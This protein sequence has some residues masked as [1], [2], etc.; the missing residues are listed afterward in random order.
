MSRVG[1][2]LVVNGQIA[3]ICGAARLGKMDVERPEARDLLHQLL[4]LIAHMAF[5]PAVIGQVLIVS[6]RFKVAAYA[7]AIEEL[8]RDATG[9]IDWMPVFHKQGELRLA[10]DDC[11]AALY[12]RCQGIWGDIPAAPEAVPAP[13]ALLE[14]S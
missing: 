13:V 12:Q 10:A 14:A 11:L 2:K 5:E 8:R 6:L 1:A 7:A 9:E 4:Y 3:L